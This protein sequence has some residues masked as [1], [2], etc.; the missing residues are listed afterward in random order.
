M[1]ISRFERSSV[2]KVTKLNFTFVGFCLKKTYQ[3]VSKSSCVGSSVI[4]ANLGFKM[5]KIE[6]FAKQ[7]IR[8]KNIA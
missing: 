2:K 5:R 3:I 8:N 4:D 7:K 1:F 6:H